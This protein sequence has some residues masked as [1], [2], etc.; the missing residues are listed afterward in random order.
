MNHDGLGVLEFVGLAVGLAL[1]L[2]LL[3]VADLCRAARD[4]QDALAALARREIDD[5]GDDDEPW[6][7]SL[8]D[9]D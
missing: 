4:R 6:R 8:R 3:R 9:D 5:E 2:A 7:A 1:A